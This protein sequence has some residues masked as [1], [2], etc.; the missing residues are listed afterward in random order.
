MPPGKHDAGLYGGGSA[1]MPPLLD[2]RVA[3]MTR[4]G[5]SRTGASRSVFH[6][7][8]LNKPRRQDAASIS[9]AAG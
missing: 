1:E 8:I 7:A 3:T 4:F 9:S 5:N 2:V 6:Q